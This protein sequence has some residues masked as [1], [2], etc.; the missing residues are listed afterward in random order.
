M[1]GSGWVAVP[2]LVVVTPGSGLIMM[3]PVSVCH[4]VSTMGQRSPPMTSWYQ[5]QASGL[6]GSPTVPSTCRLRQ[7]VAVGL[8]AAPLHEGPDGGGGGVELRDPV[9]LD[10]CP[11]GGRC[12]GWLGAPSYIT[13]VAPLASGP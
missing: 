7:V 5:I 2:G 9:A 13:L 4:Q 11:R 8:L 12:P 10:R 3:P 6:M 1:P